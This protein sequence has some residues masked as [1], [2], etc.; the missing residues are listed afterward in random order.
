MTAP[1]DSFS[2]RLREH[3]TR[4][5]EDTAVETDGVD[6]TW[7]ALD[8]EVRALAARWGHAQRDRPGP[9]HAVPGRRGGKPAPVA[10]T[11]RGEVD[12]LIATLALLVL[13][14]PQV[15]LSARDSPE[16]RR[17]LAARVGAVGVIGDTDADAL[18]GLAFTLFRHRVDDGSSERRIDREPPVDA[19]APALYLTGSGTT[20]EPKLLAY[21]QRQ[22]ARHAE[23]AYGDGGRDRVLRLAHVEYNNS[24]RLRLYTLWLGGT[25]ILR[26]GST[27]PVHR[28]CERHRVTW[29]ELA[30]MH[31]EDL[32]RASRRE[33]RLR[34]GMGVRIGGSRVP[35]A[36]RRALLAEATSTLYV[37]YGA[38]E[39]AQIAVA[40]P[41]LHDDLEPVGRVVAGVETEIRRADGSRADA[42][43]VG[44]IRIR[45]A[46]MAT[47]YIDDP[48]ASER[49]F[50]DGWFVPGDLVSMSANGILRIHGRQD[51]MMIMNGINI[52]PAEIERVLESHPAVEAAAAL[53]LASPMHGQIPIAAVELREGY[54]CTSAELVAF[55]RAA[56]GVRTPRRIAILPALPRNAL[57]KIVRRGL[58]DRIG[59]PHG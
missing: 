52:F 44:E 45:A 59:P 36:L 53:P 5:P 2:A 50:V 55:A 25:C 8:V 48:V 43:E 57:G 22:L 58:A 4:K 15:A 20:G 7:G 51:D 18:P 41:S 14:V 46:G 19:D 35:A 11:L 29:L 34:E 9:D 33:G 42:D 10:I 28:F 3:A 24:K 13:G 49:H 54:A 39:V 23:R 12:H 47:A 16:A 6:L 56:L 27:D 32:L 17:K 30:T 38:T 31:A 40:E 1:A 37:S 21:S 26:D